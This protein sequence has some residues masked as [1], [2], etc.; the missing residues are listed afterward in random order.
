MARRLVELNP[1]TMYAKEVDLRRLRREAGELRAYL[2]ALSDEQDPEGLRGRVL[3]FCEA[4]I[5]GNLELPL[6][7][8]EKPINI[9]R[10]LDS[11]GYLPKG[12][13]ELYARFFN[14]AQG[15]RAEVEH[16]IYKQGKVW[17]WM[18]FED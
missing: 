14:T 2:M 8:S 5:S 13:E 6:S 4:A 3:P 9:V 11:G 12:F 16:P 1:V 17:A 15:S 7:P 10:V 18:E